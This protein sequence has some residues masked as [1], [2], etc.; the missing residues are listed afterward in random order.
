MANFKAQGL[1]NNITIPAT[2]QIDSS[3]LL[4]CCLNRIVNIYA[5]KSC[6]ESYQS[7]LNQETTVFTNRGTTDGNICNGTFFV[8]YDFRANLV[9]TKPTTTTCSCEM[10]SQSCREPPS[11]I[12]HMTTSTMNYTTS[13]GS[14][15]FPLGKSHLRYK[16]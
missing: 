1:V 12:R 10:T 4:G 5:Q 7:S 8:C 14:S 6:F 3:C 11:T 16:G 2:V 13:S 9:D 15:T